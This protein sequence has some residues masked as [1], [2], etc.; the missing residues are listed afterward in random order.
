[1]SGQVIFMSSQTVDRLDDVLVKAGMTCRLD[2]LLDSLAERGFGAFQCDIH[3][4]F[5]SKD[6]AGSESV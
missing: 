5:D 6:A 4:S 1:M 2:P 3:V